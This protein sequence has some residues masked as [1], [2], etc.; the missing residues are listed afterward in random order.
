MKHHP[1][2]DKSYEKLLY[3]ALRKTLESILGNQCERCGCKT[4]LQIHHRNNDGDED[5]K[6][7]RGSK[8]ML[9]HYVQSNDD[10]S[11]KLALLCKYCHRSI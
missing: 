8:A 11:V 2:Y 3:E 6:K 9:K 4:D 7:F 10:P 1:E 5:R